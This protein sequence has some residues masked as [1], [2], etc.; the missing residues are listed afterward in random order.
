[1]PS[2][3]NFMF[4]LFR[5]ASKSLLLCSPTFS[6]FTIERIDLLVLKF[7]VFVRLCK[8]CKETL[9]LKVCVYYGLGEHHKCG[10]QS[11]RAAAEGGFFG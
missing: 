1:M 8:N 3:I 9:D 11:V 5:P 7:T 4:V 2:E 6:H 10:V